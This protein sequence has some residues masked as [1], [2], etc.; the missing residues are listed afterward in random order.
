MSSGI[1]GR[2]VTDPS[3]SLVMLFL[4]RCISWC[5]LSLLKAPKV[6]KVSKVSKVNWRL[7]Y[8]VRGCRYS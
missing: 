2:R 4:I 8:G 5:S 3:P 7:G 1:S 6:L